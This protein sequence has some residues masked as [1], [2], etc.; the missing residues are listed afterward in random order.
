MKITQLSNNPPLRKNKYRH[1]VISFILFSQ[2][3]LNEKSV[4]EKSIFP[5]PFSV[6]SWGPCNKTTTTKQMNKR[7]TH[8][9]N[10]SFV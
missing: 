3:F 10:A 5:L 1:F 6:L 9:F 7:E 8:T 4:E 2:V